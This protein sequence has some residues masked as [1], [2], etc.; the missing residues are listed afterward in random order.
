MHR[1]YQNESFV[2]S[3]KIIIFADISFS[4]REITYRN[5][6]CFLETT[7]EN[8][9]SEQKFFRWR[10]QIYLKQLWKST[11]GMHFL[12]RRHALTVLSVTNYWNLTIIMH[13]KHARSPANNSDFARARRPRPS[14]TGLHDREDKAPG[15]D[16]PQSS[17]PDCSIRFCKNSHQSK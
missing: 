14:P 11:S 4:S 13:S 15:E 10:G 1:T 16:S 6:Q 7:C 5:Q 12:A 2:L 8:R 3:G 17:R 9:R